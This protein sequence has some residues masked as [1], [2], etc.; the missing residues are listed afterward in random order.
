MPSSL[1]SIDDE[2]STISSRSS[3]E[4]EEYRIAQQE[5]EESLQQ[6]QQLMALVL[7]PFFGRWM[8]R[9]FSQLGSSFIYQTIKSLLNL[10]SLWKISSVGS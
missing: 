8:G 7:L 10:Y 3:E 1:A 9:R 5:W 4:D 2:V 6:L